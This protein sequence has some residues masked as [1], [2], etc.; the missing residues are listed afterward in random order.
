MG[1]RLRTGGT[2]V[3]TPAGVGGRFTF[4]D[5][6]HTPRV[7]FGLIAFVGLGRLAFIIES[8]LVDG[9]FHKANE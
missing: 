8:Q 7:V 2:G 9:N 4:R 6:G 5:T 1:E 3:L